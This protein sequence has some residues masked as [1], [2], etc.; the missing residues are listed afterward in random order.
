MK[1][2]EIV[3]F[4]IEIGVSAG[5][6]IIAGHALKSFMPTDLNRYQ[7]IAVK[8][9]SFAVTSMVST[10]AS[11]HINEYVDK[12]AGGIDA[13][14]QEAQRRAADA[15]TKRKAEEEAQVAELK[16]KLSG[17]DTDGR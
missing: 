6:G 10:A 2:R 5:V 9:G 16:K 14:R 11:N 15:E 12:F 4:A 3:K 13:G 1:K 8:V 7:T 17:D